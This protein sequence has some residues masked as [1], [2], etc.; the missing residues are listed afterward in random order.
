MNGVPVIENMNGNGHAE[1]HED[2][3]I[4]CASDSINDASDALSDE[5]DEP[6]VQPKRQKAEQAEEEVLVDDDILIDDSESEGTSSSE[7]NES[8]DNYNAQNGDS[9]S[10]DVIE[11]SSEEEVI[12]INEDDCSKSNGTGRQAIRTTA[13]NDP[14][15]DDDDT[16]TVIE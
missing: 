12:E 3:D 1:S 8:S 7:R 5:D 15:E 9:N 2:E 14:D 13:P 10:N 6:V 16:V 11:C 4:V